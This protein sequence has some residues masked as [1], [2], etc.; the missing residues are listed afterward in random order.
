M[1][2]TEYAL[3]IEGS[4]FVFGT[5]LTEPTSYSDEVPEDATYKP[6]LGRPAFTLSERLRPLE[7]NL[8]VSA[9]DFVLHNSDRTISTWFCRDP[10]DVALTYLDLSATAAANT[11]TVGNF[12]RLGSIPRYVWIAGEAMEITSQNSGNIVNVVRGL[13]GTT[14]QALEV[15]ADRMIRPRIY[16]YPYWLKGRRVRL[17]KVSGTTATLRWVGYVQDDLASSDNGNSFTIS[18]VHAWEM[19]S[20]GRWGTPQPAAALTGYDSLACVFSIW[21][22]DRSA[23]GA[24][25]TST[26]N[27]GRIFTTLAAALQDALRRLKTSLEGAGAT[28]VRSRVVPTR[29]GQRAVYVAF[30]TMSAGPGQLLLGGETYE[31][32]A[33]T[34]SGVVEHV[35]TI[36]ASDGG[37]L[38]RAGFALSTLPSSSERRATV[39]KPHTGALSRSTWT[40]VAGSRTGVTITPVL[41]GDLD[42]KTFLELDPTAHTPAGI[43]TADTTFAVVEDSAVG[44]TTFR[45]FAR[46]L[47]RDPLDYE[48]TAGRSLPA[49]GTPIDTALPLRAELRVDAPHWLEGLRSILEDDTAATAGSDSRN[50]SWTNYAATIRRARDA[51]GAV[52]YRTNGNDTIGDLITGEAA[53]RG[54]CVTVDVN[55]KLGII[56]VRAPLASETAAATITASDLLVGRGDRSQRSDDGLVTTISFETPVRTVTLVDSVALAQNKTQNTISVRS[57]SLRRDVRASSDPIEYALQMVSG[58]LG[59]WRDELWLYRLTVSAG[60]YASTATLGAVVTFDTTFS[61]NRSGGLGFSGRKGIV[62]GRSED[63]AGDTLELEVLAF[64]T[65]YGFAPCAKVASISGAVLTLASAYAGDAGDYAGSGLTGYIKTANDKGAGWFAAGD[66]IKLIQR[67]TTGAVVEEAFTVLSVNTA[68]GTITATASI[69]TV[70]T[71]WPALCSSSWVDVTFDDWS[72]SVTSQRVFAAVADETT[73]LIASTSAWQRWSP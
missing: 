73:E 53:L 1:S 68:A 3:V 60:R 13:Y 34:N 41:A 36:P 47:S 46:V 45:G 71:D 30:E 6:L 35:F 5:G 22:D 64:P 65:G 49:G 27:K 43:N 23:Q 32:T 39:V 16:S 4:P 26:S 20:R 57:Q 58:L 70:P 72:T 48:L 29:D 19:E 12:S 62:I 51:G 52:S 33:T 17:Y 63:F 21:D 67:D 66:K 56:D 61:P 18:C 9:L 37:A 55:G 44:H 54:C 40:V 15:D 69:P 28:N 11:I 7:G 10:D 2:T 50:W 14:A 42:D 25:N 38:V 31:S 8:E 59:R 24:S